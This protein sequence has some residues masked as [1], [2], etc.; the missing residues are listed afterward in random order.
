MDLSRRGPSAGGHSPPTSARSAPRH[1][2]APTTL[3]APSIL[4]SKMPETV[5]LD[6]REIT[7]Q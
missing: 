3:F 7:M 4:I 5:L 6:R 2:S 1:K